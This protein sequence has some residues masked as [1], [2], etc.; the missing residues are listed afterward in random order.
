MAGRGELMYR[1]VSRPIRPA[2]RRNGS[3][4]GHVVAEV[5]W[6]LVLFALN[7]LPGWHAIP[8]LD[9]SA[10]SLLWLVN[11]CIVARLVAHL[12]YLADGAGRF[13]PAGDYLI[14]LLDLIVAAEVL[15]EFPFDF[16]AAG[17]TWETATRLLLVAAIVI[18][19]LRA[20]GA[21]T[22]VAHVVQVHWQHTHSV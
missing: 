21:A 12:V 19:V 16:G 4:V 18:S 5:W 9:A 7:V 2:Q 1:D 15:V 10:G 8:F 20:A 14:A 6:L 3:V 22:R 11:L 17:A 13:R